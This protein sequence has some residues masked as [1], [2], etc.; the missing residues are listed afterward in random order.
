MFQNNSVSVVTGVAAGTAPHARAFKPAGE[1]H[2]PVYKLNKSKMHP[3]GASFIHIPRPKSSSRNS[4]ATFNKAKLRPSPTVNH[5]HNNNNSS[6]ISEQPFLKTVPKN[7]ETVHGSC[8]GQM[9]RVLPSCVGSTSVVGTRKRSAPPLTV[10]TLKSSL[11]LSDSHLLPKKVRE[12]GT[13]KGG[14]NK[15]EPGVLIPIVTRTFNN[16]HKNFPKSVT[17]VEKE[18][19]IVIVPPQAALEEGSLFYI[20][21]DEEGYGCTQMDVKTDRPPLNHAVAAHGNFSGVRHDSSLT[22][23]ASNQNRRTI[24]M[25]RKESPHRSKMVTYFP[26]DSHNSGLDNI[27]NGRR[28]KKIRPAGNSSVKRMLSHPS[29]QFQC[30]NNGHNSSSDIDDKSKYESVSLSPSFFR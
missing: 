4:T 19:L 5:N 29:H 7:T 11:K 1:E 17:K 22:N 18:K 12:H 30:D 13:N 2:H 9:V 15:K 14:V 21:K 28:L 8:N 27:D 10:G 26:R 20:D 24:Q 3:S 23:P 6:N 16:I 25:S